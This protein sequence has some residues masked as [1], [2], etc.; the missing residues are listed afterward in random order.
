MI[1]SVTLA[2]SS[3]VG[4]PDIF[5]AGLALSWVVNLAAVSYLRRCKAT[6]AITSGKWTEICE[7]GER[8]K[9]PPWQA[10]FVVT[11]PE[12]MGGSDAGQPAYPYIELKCGR[13]SV[14]VHSSR[15]YDADELEEFADRMNHFLWGGPTQRAD[16]AK[17]PLVG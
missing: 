11:T 9:C 14:N 6:I 7:E 4:S 3:L 13:R 16:P 1:F 15:M 5:G 8:I 2:S 12:P 10:R 17:L